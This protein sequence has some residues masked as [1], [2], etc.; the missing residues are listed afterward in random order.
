MLKYTLL[1][2]AMISL[3]SAEKKNS[4]P[5]K[6]LKT[7]LPSQI[8]KI[9]RKFEGNDERFFVELFDTDDTLLLI[10]ENNRIFNVRRCHNPNNTIILDQM[11]FGIIKNKYEQNPMKKNDTSKKGY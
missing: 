11:Y 2:F 7:I 8:K 9:E 3:Q 5:E 10:K 1:L 6:D 4:N